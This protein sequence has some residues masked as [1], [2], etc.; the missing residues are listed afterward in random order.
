MSG[1][2]IGQ[3]VSA[4]GALTLIHLGGDDPAGRTRDQVLQ[5]FSTIVPDFRG[6]CTDLPRDVDVSDALVVVRNALEDR[7]PA[8]LVREGGMAGVAENI[9]ELTERLEALQR[10]TA[11]R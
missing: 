3:D 5:R 2:R 11:S 6:T 7:S 10:R 9:H 4:P 1:I 8:L